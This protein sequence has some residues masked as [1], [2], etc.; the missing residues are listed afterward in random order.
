MN[1]CY[2]GA[3][4]L[5]YTTET[6]SEYRRVLSYDRLN[7]DAEAQGGILDAIEEI[8]ILI[9]PAVSTAALPDESD[10]PFYDTA[11]EAGA[12]LVTGNI[13]HYPEENFIMTPGQFLESLN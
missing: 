10:R 8:G 3:F 1:L 5:F 4:Q 7:I 6:F 13:K 12:V 11:K 9:E 2:S